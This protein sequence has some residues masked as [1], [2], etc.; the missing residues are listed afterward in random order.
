[1]ENY[2][3]YPSVIHVYGNFI[4]D[5][6]GYF[7]SLD[8]IESKQCTTEHLDPGQVVNGVNVY[9]FKMLKDPEIKNMFSWDMQYS[10]SDGEVNLFVCDQLNIGDPVEEVVYNTIPGETN[11]FKVTQYD[12]GYALMLDSD[13]YNE[14]G[15]N[16]HEPHVLILLDSNQGVEIPEGKI[17]VNYSFDFKTTQPLLNFILRFVFMDGDKRIIGVSEEQEIECMPG[18]EVRRQQIIRNIPNGA[19]FVAPEFQIP[20]GITGDEFFYLQKNCLLFDND[21]IGFVRN[22]EEAGLLEEMFFKDK[23]IINQVGESSVIDIDLNGFTSTEELIRLEI[24]YM[25]H[26]GENDTL[27]TTK[28]CF[29]KNGVEMNDISTNENF[30]WNEFGNPVIINELFDYFGFSGDTTINNLNG[31]KLRFKFMHGDNSEDAQVQ[32]IYVKAYYSDKEAHD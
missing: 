6:H 11:K 5:R 8:D 29:V 15:V 31:L 4:T 22:P 32:D 10:S 14:K 24:S 1:M 17:R 19:K 20:E 7:E 25:V 16:I 2:V 13:Y 3:G 27:Q 21:F 26:V 28:V 18:L 23:I 12:K 30:S 9:G